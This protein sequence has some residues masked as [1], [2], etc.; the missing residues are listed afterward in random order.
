MV[1][2]FL[3]YRRQDGETEAYLLYKD[4]TE[5]GYTV[6]FDHKSLGEGDFKVAIEEQ[7]RNAKSVVII[8]SESSFSNKIFDEND[9][10]RNE[11]RFALQY[12]KRIVGIMLENFPG[13]PEQLPEDIDP[14]RNYNFLKLYIGY[15]EAVFS[16]LTSGS[17]LPPPS[18][19]DLINRPSDEAIQKE[20]PEELLQLSRMPNMQRMQYTQLLLQIMRTFNDSPICMRFYRYIDLYDRNKGL[21]EIPEYDGDIPSDLVTYL[22]FFETLYIIIGSG[23]MQLSVLDFAYRYRFFAGCN[24]P[25][26]QKSELLPLGYQY[27]N[28]MSLYNIWC[29]YIVERYDHSVKCDSISD[30]IP[31]YDNDLHKQYAAYVFAQKPGRPMKIRFLNRNLVW[32]NLTMRVMDER[33]FE[34]CMAF[35]RD[36]L[37]TIEDNDSKNIFQPLTEKEM[38]KALREE[39]CVGLFDGETLMAQMNLILTPDDTEN[40]ILDLPADPQYDNPAIVD[41]VAVHQQVRGYSIQKSLL[42]VAECIAANHNKSGICAV[43]SPENTHSIKNFLSRGYRIVATQPKYRSTRHYLWKRLDCSAP[44]ASAGNPT[45][46]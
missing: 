14:I 40:L 29:D 26:M 37:L 44:S 10:Y 7:I 25:I 32:L 46:P 30:Q 9:V 18:A 4:L 36:M 39:C 23:T 35:Q 6:F 5:S 21:G 33:D 8:L 13:F 3:S 2:I 1:D 43:A 28:I 34:N 45:T 31:L 16:R 22:S 11:L 41:Y 17:F 38:E 12:K 20:V 15:Y 27:P 19:S 24:I 42:F